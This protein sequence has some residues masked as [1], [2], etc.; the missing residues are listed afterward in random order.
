MSE[1]W[2]NR[3]NIRAAGVNSCLTQ[4]MRGDRHAAVAA[5]LFPNERRQAGATLLS[6][7]AKQTLLVP[8][9]LTPA[10]PQSS[11]VGDAVAVWVASL[12]VL[13]RPLR[14]AIEISLEES[15]RSPDSTGNS[16][17]WFLS[18]VMLDS[19]SIIMC[20]PKLASYCGQTI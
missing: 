4:R 16:N 15:S 2:V 7:G 10:G 9:I 13:G 11:Q 5:L 19:K 18:I 17:A 8:D 1:K 3:G 6:G 20:A 12:Y 14:H